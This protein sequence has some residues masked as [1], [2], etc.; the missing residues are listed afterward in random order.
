MSRRVERL[1]G[2]VEGMI[3]TL[4]DI[5]TVMQTVQA[6]RR[7]RIW[8]WIVKQ[9]RLRHPN[10][11]KRLIMEICVYLEDHPQ[12]ARRIASTY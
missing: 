1:F 4:E 10:R 9:V 12:F 3:G 2:E 5:K 6:F 11:Q 7:L 8:W